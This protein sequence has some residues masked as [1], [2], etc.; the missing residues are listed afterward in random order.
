MVIKPEIQERIITAANQLVAEGNE[1]PT[2]EQ[3]RERMGGGS[4]SHISPVMR[5]WRENQK[6]AAIAVRDMP[7]EVR[8][9]IERIG[10]ELWRVASQLADADVEKARSECREREQAAAAERDEALR[11]VERLEASLSAERLA[12]EEGQE[13]IA[14]LETR[15]NELKA[16]T[17]AAIQKAESAS[18]R[19]HDLQAQLS[20]QAER[21]D[22][23]LA[24]L[25]E[26]QGVIDGLREDKSKLSFQVVSLES[27]LSAK[28]RELEVARASLEKADHDR[29]GLREELGTLQQHH[30]AVQAELRAASGRVEQLTDE[31]ATLRTAGEQ[32]RT[33]LS[34]T[35]SELKSTTRR[36][37]ELKAAEQHLHEARAEL[38]AC[39]AREQELRQQL[40]QAKPDQ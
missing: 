28:T 23:A 38:A 31:N 30:A 4:L 2:N 26:R 7:K 15:C 35:R 17:A 12:R 27:D 10:G 19:A 22:A 29:N 24:N 21:L 37:E 20:Q 5:A 33:Q 3:V 40:S 6:V 25:N 34:E 36:L 14:E 11:E 1:Q 32:E 39:Q 18:D 16:E 8:A 9:A 13:R